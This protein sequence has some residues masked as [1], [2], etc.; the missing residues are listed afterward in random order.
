MKGIIFNLLERVIVSKHG[1]NRWDEILDAARL[2]GAYTSLGSYPD[3]E[4]KTLIA[5]G[6]ALLGMTP[7][8]L[9]RWFGRM[10]MPLLAEQYP[11]FFVPHHSTRSF[12]L[13]LNSIIHPEVRK[14][15]PGAMCPHFQ[16]EIDENQ[17]AE[18]MLE[19]KSPRG[20]CALAHGFIE[21]AADHFSES[22]V[23]NHHRCMQ[24]DGASC[25][26]GIQA[27]APHAMGR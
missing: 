2:N 1:D 14:L 10:A 18:L 19:Y 26:L 9:L 15:H 16:F 25:L 4:L 7:D 5:A 23:V 21:G 12:V 3:E 8:E 20:L 13:A 24:Q 27:H 11:H 22:I 17:G 6:G